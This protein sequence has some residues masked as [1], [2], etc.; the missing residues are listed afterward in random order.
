MDT[1]T[2]THLKSCLLT[3][4]WL[5]ALAVPST[6]RGQIEIP[7]R[8][9]VVN[10]IPN[11]ESGEVYN[12]TEPSICVSPDGKE[13]AVHA[14]SPVP[15]DLGIS[16]TFTAAGPGATWTVGGLLYDFDATMDWSSGTSAYIA[17]LPYPP[18]K[19]MQ[20]WSSP[21]PATVGFSPIGP[22]TISGD[23]DQPRV[24]AV[25]VNGVDHVYVGFN[26]LASPHG[27]TASIYYSLDGG[28]TWT[29][30]GIEQLI[31]GAGQDSPAVPM[32]I[33]ADGKTVYALFQRWQAVLNG[34]YFADVVLVRDD[35]S[36]LDGFTDL[37]LDSLGARETLV[38]GPNLFIPWNSSLGS[39]RLGSGCSLAINPTHPN[40]VYVADTELAGSSFN[41]TVRYSSDSGQTF[42]K[43]FTSTTFA[44]SSLPAL[45]VTTEG[46]VGLLY[47]AETFYPDNLEIHFFEAYNGNFNDTADHVLASFPDN[48]PVDN[49]G[50]PYLGD[51]F[52]LTAIG[53]SFYG[54]FSAS[55]DPQAS[56]FPEGVYYQRN[57]QY[58]S[59][60]SNNF[61]VT[62][63]GGQLV[64]Q[65][66]NPVAPSIDPFF[67]YDLA[68]A[69]IH[70]PRLEF[71]AGGVL[72]PGDPLNGQDHLVW[73][74]LPSNYPMFQ[75]ESSSALGS[76]ANWSA[77]TNLTITNNLIVSPVSHLMQPVFY[78]LAQNVTG[79]QFNIFTS[80]DGNGS[81]N[82]DGVVAVAA[83]QNQTFTATP[84]NYYAVGKWY[85]DAVPVQAGSTTMTVSNVSAEHT[86]L[87]TFVASNDL[88]VTISSLPLQQGP[89][90]A[91]TGNPAWVSN[92]LSY[93]V[94]V[95]NDG[96][97]PL[98]GITISNVFDPT[99]EFVSATTTQGSVTNTGGLLTGT[100]GSMNPGATV[101]LV[102]AVLP[103]EEGSITDVVSVACDE[104]E[105]ALANNTATDLDNVL[106]ALT[107]TEQPLSQ[108]VATGDTATFFVG[109][110]GSPPLGYQWF[111]NGDLL[112]GETNATLTLNHVTS[113]E[114]GS[115][116]VAVFQIPAG[117]E[118][119]T[120]L[121][122]DAAMLTVSA[123]AFPLLV[124][125][126]ATGVSSNSAVLNGTID[127]NGS[128]A[129]AHFRYGTD[130]NYTGGEPVFS[131]F[132]TEYYDA[133]AFSYT[134]TNLAPGTTYHYQTFGFNC[135]E[136]G[137]GADQT[138][139]TVAAA[140]P[141]PTVTT[142]AATSVTANSATI[143]GSVNPNGPTATVYFQY[144]T[145]PFS[146]F[147]GGIP[148]STY[149]YPSGNYLQDYAYNLTGLTPNTT[150]YFIFEAYNT[151]SANGSLL[152]FTTATAA[153]PPPTV[154]TYA[155]NSVTANSAV[156]NG[157][158]NPNGDPSTSA[159]F[160]YGTTTG[161]G[162]TTIQ[163]GIGGTQQNFSAS[164]ASLAPS[165]TYHYRIG[166]ANT[167]GVSYGADD[168]FTTPAP[169]QLPPTVV[170][171]AASSVTLTTAVLNGNV[172]PNGDPSTS[173]FFQYGTTTS[174]GTTTTQ[175]GIGG[176]QQN[177]SA[178]IA[179]LA[180]STTYHYRIGAA[181]TGGVSYGADDT[182]TTPAPQAPPAVTTLAPTTYQ[183]GTTATLNASVNP[184][185]AATTVYFQYGFTTSY[186][187]TSTTTG[188]GSGTTGQSVSVNVAGLSKLTLYHCR[189]VAYNVGGTNYGADVSFDSGG[190]Q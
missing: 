58:G 184:E 173:A 74:M 138:F 37:P 132:T 186:G 32:A 112:A 47:L 122:S 166:A 154:V 24:Q 53:H 16:Q 26:N 78:R 28:N 179:S 114:A 43:V 151:S 175:T 76:T 163:T 169:P 46:T 44:G 20:V 128:Y 144:S 141:P 45:A 107:I 146:P 135:C 94:R 155:A 38:G 8:L 182:F 149:F 7:E 22:A 157:N 33:S 14:F 96:L 106:L 134:L 63:N 170:T 121:D 41:V 39:Q 72:Y 35:N 178:S 89:V 1:Q 56:H 171:Y 190:T 67:F 2:K 60:I 15:G 100:L 140:E 117:A 183:S 19:V 91:N 42:T 73:P 162:T 143:N 120:E 36:G 165:T 12:N 86:V 118:D 115:Y 124:T 111:F 93:T 174:Y 85:L 57:V 54:T 180:P 21:D 92:L 75:L 90:L 13:F 79:A 105:P 83:A 127:G 136:E 188:I 95:S 25:N 87:A 82:P 34:D 88:A 6:S 125:Q 84:S 130:T 164:I 10:I 9:G 30:T 187:G 61:S 137:F 66:G 64:D 65:S 103:L 59:S 29:T 158:V 133:E 62:V 50:Q 176:T 5:L 110:T 77:V 129:V 116:Y 123:P 4:P 148:T 48:N 98:T 81:L 177:F 147:Q 3:I 159:F 102:L 52:G 80:V 189:A 40:E 167:G 152:S 160:Q 131:Y 97:N 23:F 68:S 113:G 156:L 161:Y 101:T 51:Y 104:F 108:T 71:V 150:Y 49:F 109:A 119:G 31:P 27:Q 55:G 142:S 17:F 145:S 70:A 185:G 153:Q 168:T 11:N 126:P 99:V 181:N 69:M 172:D 18:T 139:T